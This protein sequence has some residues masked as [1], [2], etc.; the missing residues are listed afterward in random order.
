MMKPSIAASLIATAVLLLAGSAS[1]EPSLLV[2]KLMNEPVSLLTFGIYRLNEGIGD[3]ATNAGFNFAFATY[4]YDSNEIRIEATAGAVS[5]LGKQCV[6]DQVCEKNLR[7]SLNTFATR[8]AN[9]LAKGQWF[10]MVT[11]MFSQSGYTA[12]NFHNGKSL[13]DA[14]KD[15]SHIVKLKGTVFNTTR[16]YECRRDLESM[17]VFC[18]SKPLK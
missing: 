17:D 15:L 6:T 14:V 12:R 1:G 4:D 3:A 7:D 10:E 5:P 11:G 2:R 13:E 16:I 18:T 9:Q 8:F